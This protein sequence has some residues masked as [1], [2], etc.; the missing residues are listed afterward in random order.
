MT[1]DLLQCDVRSEGVKGAVHAV[2]GTGLAV[3]GSYNGAAAVV[4]PEP[5]LVIQTAVYFLGA[6]WEFWQCYRH[7]SGR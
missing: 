1:P 3:C 2:V 6:G 7:W 5:R 4:R